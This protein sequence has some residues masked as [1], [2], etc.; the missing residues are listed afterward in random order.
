M[1]YPSRRK[2][3]PSLRKDL[4][5]ER[6]MAVSHSVTSFLLFF[7]VSYFHLCLSLSLSLALVLSV[8][9]Y[10]FLA[11]ANGRQIERGTGYTKS[12]PLFPASNLQGRHK[13]KIE[14][15]G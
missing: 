5:G 10:F 11:S 3:S 9:V 1:N 7:V 15:R 13:E 6:E 14:H 2:L 12:V 8:P 4:P